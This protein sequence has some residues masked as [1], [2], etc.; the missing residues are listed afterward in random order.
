MKLPG[1]KKKKTPEQQQ[2][3]KIDGLATKG[4]V[5]GLVEE[6]K[7]ARR[8]QFLLSLPPMMRRRIIRMWVRD[9]KGK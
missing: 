7:K 2:L 9:A 8:Q 5:S 4:E 6:I 3:E 1:L